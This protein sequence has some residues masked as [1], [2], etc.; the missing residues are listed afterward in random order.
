M[1]VTKLGLLVEYHPWEKI[2]SVLCEGKII[3]IRAEN[4]EK[5]GRKDSEIIP[6]QT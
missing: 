5:A 3:R 1:W 6:S 2:A 4:V